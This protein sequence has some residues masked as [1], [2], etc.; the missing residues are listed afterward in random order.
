MTDTRETIEAVQGVDESGRR[1]LLNADLPT[2]SRRARLALDPGGS[3]LWLACGLVVLACR[4]AATGGDGVGESGTETGD[5]GDLG[6]AAFLAPRRLVTADWLDGRL[7]VLD[8]E[9]FVTQ[10]QSRAEA[11]LAEIDLSAYAPGPLEL[12]VTPDGHRAVVTVGPGFFQGSVG[13]LIGA[14]EVAGGGVVLVVDLLTQEVLAELVTPEPPMGVVISADGSTAYTANY[15]DDAVQGRS[16]SQIDLTMLELIGSVDVGARP[17]QLAL[18]GDMLA[19]NAAGDGTVVLLDTTVT[20]PT[21][22][23]AVVTSED[24]SY[25]LW[26]QDFPEQLLMTDSQGPA[27]VSLV[28]IATPGTPTAPTRVDMDGFPYAID[29]VGAAPEVVVLASR[30]TSVDL[31]RLM[32]GPLSVAEVGT[33]LNIGVAGFPLG[34]HVAD[35]MAVFAVPGEGQVV[36]VDLAS[37]EVEVRAWPSEPGPTF[38]AE[39]PAESAESP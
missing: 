20:P 26:M 4:P 9:G 3:L 23:G 22:I 33:P 8:Y 29:R 37:E 24:S 32:I 27:G 13:A 17:E 5:L 19:V 16:V 25:P 36:V 18:M 21:F 28:D 10:G 11:L 39:A 35:G 12:A 15:G 14:G 30:L 1:R 7:S 2:N 38:V 31:H 34:V 6:G